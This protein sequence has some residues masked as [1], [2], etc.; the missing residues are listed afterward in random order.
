[1]KM[2]H[3]DSDLAVAREGNLTGQQLVQKGAIRLRHHRIQQHRRGHHQHPSRPR[4]AGRVQ[5]QAE[6]AV[7]H[8]AGHKDLAERIGAKPRHQLPPG[9]WSGRLRVRTTPRC[10]EGM[11]GVSTAPA[12]HV[13]GLY[14]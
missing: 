7:R 5:A 3:G 6:V 8:P 11:Q 10:W 12:G 4:A 14:A 13:S 2:A 9:R 1:M